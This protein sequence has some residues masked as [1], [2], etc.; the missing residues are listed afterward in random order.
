MSKVL[1]SF[2]GKVRRK[3]GSYDKTKY[4]FDSGDIE[5]TRYFGQAL[6]RQLRPDRMVMLGTS[7]SMWDVFF[8]DIGQGN[9]FIEERLAI[10]DEV[11]GNRV[12][13]ER[14]QGL[15]PLLEKSLETPCRLRIIPYGRD[16]KEQTRILEILASEVQERDEVF[17]DLTHGF[18]ILPMLGLLSALYLQTVKKARI[19]GLYYGAYDMRDGGNEAPVLRLD[20]LLSIADWIGAVDRYDQS[21]NYGVFADLLGADNPGSPVET[22]KKAAFYERTSNSAQA[23]DQVSTFHGWFKDAQ[24][25]PP[26]ANLFREALEARISWFKEKDRAAREERLALDYLK[27]KDYLR[28]AIYGFEALVT[29]RCLEE[30]MFPD[31]YDDREK[32]D[33]SLRSKSEFNILKALR[34]SMAHGISPKDANIK[35]ALES[36]ENLRRE[37]E[38]LFKNLGISKR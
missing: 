36:E 18:R 20:G 2:L 16:S 21:G 25:L 37:L 10:V 35:R 23:R 7:G 11:D 34:N 9:E 15:T 27:R 13:E 6:T 12:G 8:D 5:E 30:R 38:K 26:A 17:I 32:A 22:L 29:R 14:L 28:A 33:I 31:N 4:R 24:D 19:G 1:I 3:E